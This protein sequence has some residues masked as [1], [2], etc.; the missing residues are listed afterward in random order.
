MESLNPEFA[1]Y[2][3]KNKC[4]RIDTVF[5]LKSEVSEGVVSLLAQIW[6]KIAAKKKK[7]IC[8]SC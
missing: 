5:L 8:G 3:S 4:T 6:S 2:G 1:F 7:F